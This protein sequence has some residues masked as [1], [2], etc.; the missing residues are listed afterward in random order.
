MQTLAPFVR[1]C[2]QEKTITADE[3]ILPEYIKPLKHPSLFRI[4]VAFNIGGVFKAVIKRHGKIE[5]VK[6]NEGSSLVADCLYIFDILVQKWDEINFQYSA[7]GILKVLRIQEIV[8][9]TQ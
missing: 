1:A 2:A 4:M 5:I 8:V 3:N 7:S 9:G 6:F